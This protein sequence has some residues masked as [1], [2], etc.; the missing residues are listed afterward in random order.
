MCAPIVGYGKNFRESCS[1]GKRLGIIGCGR[2]G[3][4]M[5]KYA[6]AFGMDVVGYDPYL[7]RFPGDIR[8]VTLN[9]MFESS[10]FVSVH[11]HLSDETKGLVSA[12]L[13]DR[14]TPGLIFLNTSRGAIVDEHALLNALESGRV[15]AAGLDVLVGEPDIRG[16]SL[17][18][19]RKVP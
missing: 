10:N 8:R 18:E 6:K 5:A 4:W 7:D 17:S 15:G 12:D 2:I 14:A 11:V 3:T 16:S 19:L 9:E 13:L 1:I